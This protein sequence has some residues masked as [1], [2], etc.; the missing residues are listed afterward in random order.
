MGRI[1]VFLVTVFCVSLCFPMVDNDLTLDETFASHVNALGSQNLSPHEGEFAIEKIDFNRS[2]SSFSIK[3]S[4]AGG[5]YLLSG[6]AGSLNGDC[7]YAIK[8]PIISHLNHNFTVNWSIDLL[9]WCLVEFD[10]FES[11]VSF[12]LND[13]YLS[14][15]ASLL[16]N[17]FGSDATDDAMRIISVTSQNVTRYSTS[18]DLTTNLEGLYNN[19]L[20]PDVYFSLTQ[21]GGFML[22]GTT[23]DKVI[24]N[25][26]TEGNANSRRNDRYMSA[27]PFYECLASYKV[28]TP[29]FTKYDHQ[30]LQQIFYIASGNDDGQKFAGFS[31][32]FENQTYNVFLMSK[33]NNANCNGGSSS[34]TINQSTYSSN[35]ESV[36]KLNSRGEVYDIT[37]ADFAFTMVE[38]LY[39]FGPEKNST[40]IAFWDSTTTWNSSTEITAGGITTGISFIRSGELIAKNPESDVGTSGT[41]R[42]KKFANSGPPQLMPIV[43]KNE[44]IIIQSFYTGTFNGLYIPNFS[45][46]LVE[47]DYAGNYTPPVFYNLSSTTVSNF[48]RASNHFLLTQNLTIKTGVQ[49]DNGYHLEGFP[50]SSLV[51]PILHVYSFDNDNDFLAN[52]IDPFPSEPTQWSDGDADGYG[53]NPNGYQADDCSMTFGTSWRDLF[54]CQDSDNDGQSNTNDAFPNMNSQWLDFDSDGYGDNLSGF[55][56]DSCITNFGESRRGSVFGCVDSDF[57]GWA[58]VI[59]DFSNDSSQ[60]LDTDGDGYG[61]EIGGY[62]GDSCKFVQGNSTIDRFGCIDDDGDGY[63]NLNDDLPT[64]PTQHLD[65]DGDGY[66][67]N[68]SANATMSDAFPND[69]TQWNDTDGDGYGDNPYG[70]LGDWFPNDPNRWQDSDRDGVADED[71]TF[72]TDAT[73]TED[74]DGDGYGDNP[75]GTNPDRFPDDSNEW[76]DTDGDGYGNNGDSFPNDGT[77]W[78]DTDADGHGDNPYGTLGDWFPNDPS[79]WQDSDQDGVAD[80][81]DAFVNENS[82]NSDQDGDGF[83]DNPNG[84]RADQFPN[85]PSEWYDSDGDGYGNN[86]DKFPN[87]GTQWN[88]TDEDGYGD[89]PFGTQGDWFPNDPSRWQDSDRDGVADQ[90]DAFPNEIT[91]WDDTDGDGYGDEATGNRGDVFPNDDA[92]WLDSDMDGLGDNAD[93]FPF[94][95]TQK[96]DADGDGMGDNPMGIG[97]DKFPEDAT[98]W[99]DIDGDGYG[100][101]PNGTSPDAFITDATQWSD[102]DGDGYGD[103]PAGR[104]YDQ[105]PLN[106]TQWLDEDGDGLGDNLNGT[107]ADTSLNDFDNDGYNDSIDP[108][109][110]LASPGDLDNDGVLDVN[111]LFPDDS[112]E[113]SDY[114]DDGEG[115][116]ADT[117]DDN[118]GWADTDEVRLGTDPFGAADVPIDS[119][120]IVI[121][122]TAVGLGAWDLIG[123]FGGIPLFMWIGFGFVTRNGRTAK[124]E[125]LLREAQ[126]RDELE[127]VA[128]MWEYSLMLRMLGPHQGIRL[129]RLRAE[130][131]DIFESQNQKLSSIES[132]QKKSNME[133]NDSTEIQTKSLPVIDSNVPSIDAES[134]PDEKGYEWHTNE[135]GISWYRNEGSNSEWQRFEA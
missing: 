44:S 85:D 90:D 69:G 96:V 117:D 2:S 52:Q 88:D 4:S 64:N 70:T 108:L 124:Y 16:Y 36:I 57:D 60:W 86:G 113:W 41:F 71:D 11:N 77:Q 3:E 121:P 19:D 51:Q 120:E 72:P 123:M 9:G 40:Q 6:S 132:E 56:G 15:H 99:G 135:E 45:Y 61:D 24:I 46:P 14:T 39:S 59:D 30:G 49:G 103:N 13:M 110:K 111:D 116:N 62:N 131:D 82:Q 81:D 17:P 42:P 28:D 128:R 53:D 32:N 106:P 125:N 67:E 91:Q 105:F 23:T 126:T 66:G 58:D 129:E 122:G 97:A 31:Q 118:D 92:E 10:V 7:S 100:D 89:N 84:T 133:L 35:S 65:R 107:N 127:D 114:D 134:I 38:N 8:D 79:R 47:F 75:N 12:M 22:G 93:A 20:Y 112:R 95:P 98:Q 115:D 109:P 50:T 74:T 1:A 76:K 29:W 21:D 130:L 55:Q 18:L 26:T 83:G 5:F 87:D 48:S 63:S 101:N 119:F 102:E 37:N 43:V 25:G 54:G 73:Q 94:D 33:Q 27:P 78:N 34:W 104:L 68:I 80:E